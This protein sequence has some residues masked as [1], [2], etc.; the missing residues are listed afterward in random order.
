M[1]GESRDVLMDNKNDYFSE[2]GSNDEALKFQA[3]IHIESAPLS[4]SEEFEEPENTPNFFQG[5]VGYLKE[6][7]DL[8]SAEFIATLKAS[9][10]GKKEESYS[11]KLIF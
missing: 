1:V 9:A 3:P 10:Q 6:H 8:N 2:A 4:S 7:P 11:L 5:A